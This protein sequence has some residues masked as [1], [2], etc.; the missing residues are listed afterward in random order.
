M[1]H[2]Q[3]CCIFRYYRERR[4]RADYV[5]RKICLSVALSPVCAICRYALT[6][7]KSQ[8]GCENLSMVKVQVSAKFTIPVLNLPY[9]VKAMQQT[10]SNKHNRLNSKKPGFWC[11]LNV[12]ICLYQGLTFTYEAAHWITQTCKKVYCS[13]PLFPSPLCSDL[14]ASLLFLWQPLCHLSSLLSLLKY[15][16]LSA[17]TCMAWSLP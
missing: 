17:P 10:P 11:I 7:N 15:L 6:E 9:Q 4:P 8:Q 13:F 2:L 5:L 16:L 1:V 14:K 12:S 3:D